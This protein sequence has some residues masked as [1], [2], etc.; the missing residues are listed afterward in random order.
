MPYLLSPSR[1]FW[2]D[3]M[4]VIGLC[5]TEPSPTAATTWPALFQMPRGFQQEQDNLQID[6]PRGRRNREVPGSDRNGIQEKAADGRIRKSL[7]HSRA[8]RSIGWLPV[9][10]GG[11][12]L[13]NGSLRRQDEGLECC[14]NQSP[15]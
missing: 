1:H 4:T 11:L 8:T 15:K 5:P 3:W 12:N 10:F 7:E 9:H 2:T 6:N 14:L 13:R